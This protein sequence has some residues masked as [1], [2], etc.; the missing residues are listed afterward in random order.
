[1]PCQPSKARHNTR[2][3]WVGR[4]SLVMEIT[5]SLGSPN[6]EYFREQNYS[7]LREL[8]CDLARDELRWLWLQS[9]WRIKN[10]A[11][12]IRTSIQLSGKEDF[13]ATHNIMCQLNIRTQA[14]YP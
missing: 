11:K 10:R 4:I 2:P 12:R 14:A 13:L 3:N 5:P 6:L 9:A 7:N 8:G 1:M